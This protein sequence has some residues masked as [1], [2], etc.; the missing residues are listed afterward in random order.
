MRK[1]RQ[2]CLHHWPVAMADDGNNETGQMGR[3]GSHQGVIVPV[4]ALYC[5]YKFLCPTVIIPE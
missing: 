5:C 2:Q 3:K 4:S 1:I